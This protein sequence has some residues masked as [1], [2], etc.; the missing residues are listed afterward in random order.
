[1][2]IIIRDT[3]FAQATARGKAGVTIIR[4]SGSNALSILQKLTKQEKF[5]SHKFY[6][7]NL[8]VIARN[9]ESKQFIDC[10]ATNRS[11][12][13]EIIDRAMVVYFKS[14]NSFTGEN[15][16]ELHTHGSIAVVKLIYQVLFSLGLRLAEPGEFSKRAF[17]NGKMDLT[18]AEGLADLIEAETITQ[19]RHAML[20]MSGEFE[21]ICSNWRQELLKILSLIEVYIDFPDENIPEEVLGNSLKMIDNLKNSLANMLKDNRRGERLRNGIIMAVLGPPNA[22]KSSMLNYLAKRDIA[23]IS[24]IAGTTRDV[25]ETHLDIGGYPIILADTAGL[26][27]TE[28]SIEKEGIARAI[29]AA[30]NADIKLIMLDVREIEKVSELLLDL[31]D[32]NSIIIANKIDLAELDINKNIAAGHKIHPISLKTGIGIDKLFDTIIEKAENLA[33]TQ[34]HTMITRER[35][36]SEISMAK[37]ALDGCDLTGDLVLAAEDIRIAARHL[38]LLTGR[39]E[40]EEILGEIFSNFCIGK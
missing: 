36:R 5:E 7:C 25:I 23:I 33:G 2:T 1:M 15:I 20:H 37:L 4:I 34:N 31:L 28:D 35:H 24:D 12:D 9:K 10:S 40:I 18:A 11:D 8:L 13:D 14:P 19:H 3:I 26:R 27:H 29:K 17:L 32:E 22:G 16:V 6:L 21:K 30:K 38:S 39:I